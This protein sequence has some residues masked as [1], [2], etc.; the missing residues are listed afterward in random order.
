MSEHSSGSA[1]RRVPAKPADTGRR[2]SPRG[3]G[4]YSPIPPVPSLPRSE[5]A[6]LRDRAGPLGLLFWQ[7]LSDVLLW[8]AADQRVGLFQP[9]GRGQTEALAY[10]LREV[11]ELADPIAELVQVSAMP[12]LASPERVAEACGQ[13]MRWAEQHGMK[14]TAAQFAEL[15]ARLEPDSSSRCYTAGRT[16]RHVGDAGRAAMWFR[17]AERLARRAG[18]QIDFAIAH[19][20]YGNLDY[21]LGRYREAE[22]HMEKAAR[23]ALR[24]GRKSLAA[25]C[26]HDLMR[27][28]A[29]NGRSESAINRAGRA[30]DLYPLRHPRFPLFAYDVA[31]MFVT[32]GYFSSAV[33]VLRDVLPFVADDPERIRICGVLARCAAAVR[34]RITYTRASAEALRLAA[35]DDERGPSTIY[36]LAEGARSL[37]EYDRA[38]ALARR[39]LAAADLRE[40]GGLTSAITTLLDDLATH[41]GGD[42]DRIPDAGSPVDLLRERILDSLGKLKAG[43]HR[44][45]RVPPEDYL[46]TAPSHCGQ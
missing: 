36:Q 42:V 28:A 46:I 23:A 7:C 44:G 8:C 31:W 43:K 3:H 13:V 37:E 11:P 20:G 10:T 9:R 39:A 5:L 15:A 30:L 27:V 22:E 19:L 21:N 33:L 34:D 25:S 35:L 24:A 12:E 45:R 26:E 6:I 40:F 16:C 1:D 2:G 17:R 18:N 38:E 4:R 14:E 29:D 32:M 41:S